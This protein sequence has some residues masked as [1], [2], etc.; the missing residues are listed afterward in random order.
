MAGNYVCS[1]TLGTLNN[2]NDQ[3]A[4][5]T[6]STLRNGRL[7]YGPSPFDHRQ[8]VNIYGSYDLPIGRAV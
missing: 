3:T 1:H 7:N 4:T 6:W 8:V 2:L 5:T